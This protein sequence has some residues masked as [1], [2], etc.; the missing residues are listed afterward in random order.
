MTLVIV[1]E[2]KVWRERLGSWYMTVPKIWINIHVDTSKKSETVIVVI[3]R[4]IVIMPKSVT[5]EEIER[6]KRFLE[7][8]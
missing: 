4:Y 8:V 5:Q 7:G 2:R 1:E 3:G 6:V